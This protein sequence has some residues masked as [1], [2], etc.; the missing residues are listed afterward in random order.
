MNEYIRQCPGS[1]GAMLR[2]YRGVRGLTQAELAERSGLSVAAIQ[3]YE[4][5]RRPAA[6]TTSLGRLASALQV[7]AGAL[8]PADVGQPVLVDQPTWT[9]A[10]SRLGRRSLLDE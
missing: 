10:G 8:L 6:T 2:Y 1:L 5:G 7:P 4:S 3:G 9:R